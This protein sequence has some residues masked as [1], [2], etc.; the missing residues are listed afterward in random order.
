MQFSEQFLQF[1]QKWAAYIEQHPKE[2]AVEHDIDWPSPC[3]DAEDVR[4]GF[5]MVKWSPLRRDVGKSFTDLEEAVALKLHPDIWTFYGAYL[6]NSIHVMF[7]GKRYE[8]IQTWNDQD[9]ERLQKNIIGHLLTKQRLRQTPTIF[10]GLTEQEDEILSVDNETG[11]VWVERA[12]KEAHEKVANS[13]G[14]FLLAGN[15]AV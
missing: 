3:E 5:R 14:E 2:C 10:I 12:G 7:D 9:F 1:M 6:S 4:Y 8:L 15:F 13:L 11:A